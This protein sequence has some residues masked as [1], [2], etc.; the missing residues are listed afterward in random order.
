MVKK[1]DLFTNQSHQNYLNNRLIMEKFK[2]LVEIPT[3]AATPSRVHLYAIEGGAKNKVVYQ[4]NLCPFGGK[5]GF[6]YS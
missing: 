6:R 3:P 1:K 4:T 5:S 2:P